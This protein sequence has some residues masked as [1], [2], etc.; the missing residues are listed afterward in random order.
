MLGF[1]AFA[2]AGCAGS[3]DRH[4]GVYSDAAFESTWRVA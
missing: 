1:A 2:L 3:A 4:C